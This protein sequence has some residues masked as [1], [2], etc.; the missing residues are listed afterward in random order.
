MPDQAIMQSEQKT[1]NQSWWNNKTL[2][3]PFNN[4][5]EVV[6]VPETKFKIKV[7]GQDLEVTQDEL[8][9]LAQQ[10][11]DYTK[12]SQLLADERKALKAQEERVAGM[13]AIVDEMDAD[14]KLK[15]ALNKVYSDHKAGRV[16]KP[17]IADKNLK[18]ID[19][20]IAEASDPAVKQ[21]LMEI[22]E[23]ITENAKEIAE[24]IANEKIAKIQ[25]E[26]T[27]LKNASTVGHNEK[28]EGQ[29]SKLEEKFGVDLISKYRDDIKA[30]S[31]KYPNQPAQKL[32]YHFADDSEIETAIV[33]NAKKKE[34][35]DLDRKKRNASPSAGGSF[36]AKS[37][38]V[39][40][41]AGRVTA[42]SI[43]QRVKERLGR[44]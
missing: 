25:A 12:K 7:D 39:K 8:I 42:S 22:K 23:I 44:A 13:K 9:I 26:L 34:K 37:E 40:D 15:E 18:L 21:D 10:G 31:L 33:N 17:E 43:L 14:P 1:Q 36:T 4:R 20:R 6:V 29:L 19:K 27:L 35:E 11:K 28:V 41:K 16:S 38:L 2:P 30:M 5:G 32:L 24:Q 3:F